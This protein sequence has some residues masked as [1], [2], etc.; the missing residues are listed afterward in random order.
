MACCETSTT[1]CSIHRSNQKQVKRH[2][3][4]YYWLV[5]AQSLHKLRS[6]CGW[7]IYRIESNY[8]YKIFVI[9]I[10]VILVSFIVC[11]WYKV[12]QLLL[13]V[14]KHVSKGHAD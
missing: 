3:S 4:H 14:Q 8:L 9:G 12:L 2:F 7:I 6:K 11:L 5:P 10:P 1:A 13:V